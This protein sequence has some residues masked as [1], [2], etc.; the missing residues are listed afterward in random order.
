V[1]VRSTSG[2]DS[3]V[4]PLRHVGPV[5][6]LTLSCDGRLVAATADANRV[7]VWDARSGSRVVDWQA[8]YPL[9]DVEFSKDA[10]LLAMLGLGGGV[11]VWGMAE[12]DVVAEPIDVKTASPAPDDGGEKP[13][14]FT[15]DDALLV[16]RTATGLRVIRRE[17]FRPL[18]TLLGEFH[19]RKE[20]S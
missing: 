20:R 5:E 17:A 10:G 1:H 2:A 13:L 19:A 11:I 7:R 15:A 3:G 14:T 18:P 9:A 8:P 4:G 16:A 12:H 6:R